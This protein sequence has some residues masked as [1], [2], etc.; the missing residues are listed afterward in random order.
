MD[1]AESIGDVRW[2]KNAA[3]RLEDALDALDWCGEY[4]GQGFFHFSWAIEG[5]DVTGIFQFEDPDDH[6]MFT[7]RWVR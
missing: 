6:M 2:A 7:L 3:V 1:R 5:S 4:R